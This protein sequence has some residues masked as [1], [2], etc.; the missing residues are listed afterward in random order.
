MKYTKVKNIAQYNQYCKIH[1]E[2]FINEK[3]EDIDEIA[4]LEVLI[5]E[6]DNRIKRDKFKDLNPVE[7]LRSLLKDSDITQ[8]ELSKQLNVSRQLISDVL[9][10]RRNISK[11]LVVKLSD[12][13]SMSQEAFSRTYFSERPDLSISITNKNIGSLVGEPLSE[14]MPS[15]T[16]TKTGIHKTSGKRTRTNSRKGDDLTKI[17]GIGPKAMERLN[18]AGIY[19]YK[20]LSVASRMRIENIFQTNYRLKHDSIYWPDRARKMYS[21]KV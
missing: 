7:L 14:E 18:K 15:R 5:E 8:V 12:F 13:F 21:L 10:Y 4:L 11:N 2:L 6:Y 20:Q 3:K 16:R 19:T 9:S 1:E 17:K